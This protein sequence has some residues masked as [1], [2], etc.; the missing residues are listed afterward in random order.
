MIWFL[1][2]CALNALLAFLWLFFYGRSLSF[3]VASLHFTPGIPA[4][5]GLLLADGLIFFL[6]FRSK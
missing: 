5:A 4:A 3:H 1:V 2:I 6:W